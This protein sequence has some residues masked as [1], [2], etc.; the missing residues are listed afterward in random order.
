MTA[1]FLALAV[2]TAQPSRR[3]FI[4]TSD[5]VD[6]ARQVARDSGF[7]VSDRRIFYV[8]TLDSSDRARLP[9]FESVAVYQNDHIVLEVSIHEETGQVVDS[10]RCLLF[11]YPD[12]VAFGV[13]VR[14]AGGAKPLTRA[15]LGELCGC[16]LKVMRVPRKATSSGRSRH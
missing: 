3:V 4:P 7:N 16:E 12:V 8:D 1:T 13:E 6:V 15:Q 2:L 9:G 5:L 10:T 14:K 11:E